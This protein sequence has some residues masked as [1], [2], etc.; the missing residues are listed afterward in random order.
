MLLQIATDA[1]YP[2]SV[3]SQ[4]L[5]E[6]EDWNPDE[7]LPILSSVITGEDNPILVSE[8]ADALSDMETTEALEILTNAYES[9]DN[10][11]LK[12]QVL[13][14]IADSELPSVLGFL[15]DVALTTDDDMSSFVNQTLRNSIANSFA[16]PCYQANLTQKSFHL[17]FPYSQFICS[18]SA[19]SEY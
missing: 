1:D 16:C 19:Q 4:I 3:R 7:V 13:D 10:V 11:D 12:N 2:V 6:M 14:E 8:A 17:Y 5:D 9:I 18:L 15:T